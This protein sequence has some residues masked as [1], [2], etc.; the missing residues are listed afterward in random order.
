MDIQDQGR[1]VGLGRAGT[2]SSVTGPEGDR[3]SAKER[4]ADFQAAGAAQAKTCGWLGE[5]LRGRTRPLCSSK[6]E[7]REGGPGRLCRRLIPCPK[8]GLERRA[9]RARRLAASR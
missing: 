8:D 1:A 4:T 3:L 9:C 5:A 2:A 6:S 7:S